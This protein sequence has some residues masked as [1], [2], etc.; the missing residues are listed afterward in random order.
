MKLNLDYLH[1]LSIAVPTA[2]TVNMVLVGCG[3]TGSWLAPTVVRVAR[4]LREK[5]QTKTA[6]TFIDP[7]VVEPKNCYRQNF[8]E[9]EVGRN[10]AE[11]LAFR[12]GLA[13]GMEVAAYPYGVEGIN[14]LKV[15]KRYQS[16]AEVHVVIGCVDSGKARRDIGKHLVDHGREGLGPFFWLDCGNGK[17]S[18]QVMLG[19]FSYERHPR[20]QE[21][22]KK[23]MFPMP[24]YCTWSPWP[25]EQM[26]DLLEEDGAVKAP[27]ENLSCADLALLDSQG[28]TINQAMAAQ[29]SDFL[30]RLLVTHNL[31][32]YATFI[33]LAAGTTISRYLTENWLRSAWKKIER[34]SWREPAQKN[35]QM[36]YRNRVANENGAYNAQEF[37]ETE[38][39]PEEEEFEDEDSVLPNGRS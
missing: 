28:L 27:D 5:F 9:A 25:Q 33:D 26:P 15:E 34:K 24:G 35:V 8:C 38:E 19:G 29:A 11:T 23:P 32:R 36:G 1:A 37:D 18:G 17:Q 4:L 39:D 7:D 6:V 3:G 2:K 10:K 30:I 20:Y 14:F 31:N 13:W 12:Y 21:H 22:D 16:S